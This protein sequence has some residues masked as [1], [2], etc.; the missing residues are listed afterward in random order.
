[1]SDEPSIPHGRLGRTALV[2]HGVAVAAIIIAYISFTLAEHGHEETQFDYVFG[3][4]ALSS[5]LV[6]FTWSFVLAAR[7]FRARENPKLASVVL[8][9]GAFQAFL[10]IAAFAG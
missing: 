4:M 8:A 6:L 9:I 5:Y 2:V 10:I 1:M 7:S 3:C